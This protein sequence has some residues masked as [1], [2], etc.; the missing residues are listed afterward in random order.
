MENRGLLSHFWRKIFGLCCILS[1]KTKQFWVGANIGVF[2]SNEQRQR[3]DEYS[4]IPQKREMDVRESIISLDQDDW[5]LIRWCLKEIPVLFCFCE[6][7]HG[8]VLLCSGDSQSTRKTLACWNESRGGLLSWSQG[9]N[10]SSMKT[11]RV[12]SQPGEEKVLEA[13]RAMCRSWREVQEGWR[14]TFGKSM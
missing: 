12:G 14:G 2:G 1:L 7:P 9:W 3:I 4:Q 5:F 13:H 8:S 11:E 6:I 10:A